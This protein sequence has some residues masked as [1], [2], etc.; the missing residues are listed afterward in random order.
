MYNP[1]FF[2]PTDIED[3]K[4]IILTEE[5]CS[6]EWRWE[7]ETKWN[8]KMLDTFFD[9]NEDS[10]VLDWGCGIGRMSKV[11]IDTYGCRVIGVDLNNDM[12]SYAKEYVNSNRFIPIQT[13]DAYNKIKPNTI[14]HAISIWVFQHSI[15]I[16]EEIPFIKDCIRP[17]GQIFVV[18][19]I[20]KAIPSSGEIEYYDDGVSTQ[21]LLDQNFVVQ[22][23]GTIPLKYTTEQIYKTSWWAILAKQ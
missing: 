16:Q 20:S 13:S 15:N 3:A 10:V 12:L 19:N 9:I 18:E 5:G 7:V 11:L 21:P 14:T 6:S 4:K 22:S 23:H 8:A 2:Q 17:G 1:D